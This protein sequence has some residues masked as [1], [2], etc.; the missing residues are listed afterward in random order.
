MAAYRRLRQEMGRRRPIGDHSLLRLDGQI[1]GF[2][3]STHQLLSDHGLVK[4]ANKNHLSIKL[5][6]SMKLLQCS[7]VI[8]IVWKENFTW[9]SNNGS[10]CIEMRGLGRE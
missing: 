5:S 2:H 10:V 7:S 1:T 3:P 6:I 4:T 9:G 8:T